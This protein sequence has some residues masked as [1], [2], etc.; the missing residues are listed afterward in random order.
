MFIHY[1]GYRKGGLVK[2]GNPCDLTPQNSN[3]VG[4]GWGPRICILTN[5]P[6]AAV[7]SGLEKLQA[8]G[9]GQEGPGGFSRPPLNSFSH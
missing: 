7:L 2:N 4:L 6:A 1:W 5:S 8:R 9:C 3:L